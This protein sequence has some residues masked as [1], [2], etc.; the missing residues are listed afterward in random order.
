MC[1]RF[2]FTESAQVIERQ[3]ETKNE[4][5]PELALNWNISPTTPIY[6]V[7]GE[8]PSG[9]SR[10]IDIAKWGLVPG[11]SKDA[12][13]A[14]NAINARS[15]SIAEKPSFKDAF[16]SRRCI[17]PVTGY[18]EWATE[19]GIYPP[20]QPFYIH[21]SDQQLL[22][23]AGL[24]EYWIDPVTREKVTTAAIITREAV[25]ELAAIHHRMP[26]FLNSDRWSDWLTIDRVRETEVDQYLA[27]LDTPDPLAGIE[28]RPVSSRVN[29]A[30]NHGPDLIEPIE[31]GEPETLF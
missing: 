21:R 22:A 19:L 17:I 2:T 24:Y 25:G 6:F 16:R 28:Y 15:E 7:R 12:S 29:S 11:W 14:S 27:L 31:L 4:T 10:T 8:S 23:I 3:F 30:A 20:K 9:N 1:G 13:R 26:V 18:Y 5:I